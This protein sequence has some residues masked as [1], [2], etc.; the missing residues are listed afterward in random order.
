MKYL[1]E[2]TTLTAI[3]DAVRTKGNTSDLIKVSELPNAIINLPS[4]GEP[5]LRSLVVNV[6]GVFNPPDGVDGFNMVTVNVPSGGG[7]ELPEE[8]FNLTGDCKYTFFNNKWKWF[9]EMYGDKVN[10][11]A[12]TDASYMFQKSNELVEIPFD[13]NITDTNRNLSQCFQGCYKLTYAPYIIGGERTPPTGIYNGT[14]SF[15]MLFQDCYMLREIPYDYFWKMVPNKDFWDIHKTYSVSNSGIFNY[16]YSLRELPDISMLGYAGT[17]SYS[18]MYSNFLT[19]DYSLNKVNNIPVNGT[20]TSNAFGS[21]MSKCNRV[22]E[23]T[24]E[25]NEDGTPKTAE[26]N[27]QTINLAGYNGIGYVTSSSDKGNI[28]NYNSGI[29]A[30]KEV[31]DDATYQALKDDPDWFSSNKEY[32]RYNHDSAVRTI[33]SLP[34]TSAFG[35]GNTIAFIGAAGALTDG[36][37]INTLTEEEIAVAAAKGWTVSLV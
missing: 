5:V 10:T 35:G 36:G 7:V 17:A 9:I 27:K 11:N 30:D 29:T 26:W 13:I 37:A 3:G 34:D 14:L 15:S 32:G 1:I 23:I 18:S 16:C 22:S 28:L 19:N 33:N 24:F 25:I 2:D 31:Y 4:G 12:I 21:F 8:A 6:N 20:Y